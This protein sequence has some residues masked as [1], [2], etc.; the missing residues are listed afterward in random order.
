MNV[1][2]VCIFAWQHSYNGKNKSVS[3]LSQAPRESAAKDSN[4]LCSGKRILEHRIFTEMV[5]FFVCVLCFV[6]LY[7]FNLFHLIFYSKMACHPLKW[8]K[9]SFG[10]RV[11]FNDA[12]ISNEA[13]NL[14]AL[15]LR[16]KKSNTT[17]YLCSHVH[18]KSNKLNLIL[19][20]AIHVDDTR[21]Q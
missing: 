11:S 6:S 13:S 20:S 2:C 4:V 7:V 19:I 1:K 8:S 21:F 10:A 16:G 5:V 15:G 14:R 3:A 12:I 18:K 17:N 9:C